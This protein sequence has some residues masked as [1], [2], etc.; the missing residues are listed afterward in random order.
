LPYETII[1]NADEVFHIFPETDNLR[2]PVFAS[3]PSGSIK[4]AAKKDIS[5]L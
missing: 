2:V 5:R 3:E 1:T 4:L